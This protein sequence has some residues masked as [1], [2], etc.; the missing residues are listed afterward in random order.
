MGVMTIDE[1]GNHEDRNIILRALGTKPEVAVT[2]WEKPFPVRANDSFVLC[3]DG[4]FDVVSDEEIKATV[5]NE[6]PVA[7][8]RKLIELAKAN[9]GYDNITV[10]IVRALKKPV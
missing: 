3:T 6:T 4:L 1:A 7:G 5:T 9:G 8:C 10:G 2:V